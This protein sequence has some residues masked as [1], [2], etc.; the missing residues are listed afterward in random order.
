MATTKTAK[1][2]PKRASQSVHSN[3]GSRAKGARKSRGKRP[4]TIAASRGL[5][6]RRIL[7]TSPPY[8][9]TSEGKNSRVLYSRK[10]IDEWLQARVRKSTSDHTTAVQATAGA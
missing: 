9:K 5:A 2:Q 7:G 3:L 4:R 6:K 1:R 10:A 8:I